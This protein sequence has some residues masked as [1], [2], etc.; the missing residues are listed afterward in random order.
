MF[1]LVK[2]CPPF[3]FFSH[4]ILLVLLFLLFFIPLLFLLFFLLFILL[5]ILLFLLVLL[6]FFLV[7]L[8]PS[9]IKKFFEPVFQQGKR[10]QAA[11]KHVDEIKKAKMKTPFVTVRTLCPCHS[12]QMYLS[13][14]PF[15]SSIFVISLCMPFYSS[16]II[17]HCS[18]YR[19][20]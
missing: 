20:F 4:F 3:L 11:F 19:Y 12:L 5:L 1:I 7:A 18:Y 2:H 6:L 13:T 8:T 9:D 10:I 16:F 15:C 17:A 14:H